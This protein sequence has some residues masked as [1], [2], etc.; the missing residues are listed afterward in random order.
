LARSPEHK[1]MAYFMLADIY[2][3]KKQPQQVRQALASANQYKA[4]IR[5]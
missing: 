2:N 5:N 1:A 3:R 4:Q